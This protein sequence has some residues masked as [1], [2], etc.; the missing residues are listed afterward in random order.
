MYPANQGESVTAAPSSGNA[1]ATGRVAPLFEL[2]G[3]GKQFPG[4]KALDDVSFEIQAGEIHML[5][6][7]NGAGK[8]S[9]M[10]VLC[11]AYS[12]DQGEFFHHGE[13]VRIN[14][15][16]AAQ[17]LGVAVIFQEFSLIPYLNIAQNIFL[18]REPRERFPGMV[19]RDRMHAEARKL[20]DLLGQDL[21]TGTLVHTLGVAQQQMVEI[22]K[23]LS[24]NA[25]ILVPDEPTSALSERETERLFAVLKNLKRQGVA[26]IYIS[27]RLAEVFLLG[28]RI[29]VL[30]DGK[31]VGS[32]LPT[33]T[34][35]DQ[36][37]SLMIGR[38]VDTSYARGMNEANGV[39][40][41]EVHDMA[42]ENGVADINIEVRVG[43]I[44]GLVGLVGAGRT[45]VA[46]AIFGVDRV[47]RGEIRIGGAARTGG[48]DQAALLGAALIPENWK[49]LR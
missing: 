48:P 29:T 28:D 15:L 20:L 24:Q 43:E 41:L 45:E 47:T 12:A 49:G 40:V 23:A 36:L 7:E 1:A 32:M 14:S 39:M 10:K 33:E 34:T 46:R 17:A 27:H 18:G 3:I 5:L 25:R 44:V 6:G 8:S 30:R 42:A 22:A 11:G 31:K 26:M 37:V 9:L 16:A 4:V 38:K 21:D 35:P 19:D 13:A 2:R